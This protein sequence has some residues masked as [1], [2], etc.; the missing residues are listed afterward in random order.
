MPKELAVYDEDDIMME[1]MV[2]TMFMVMFIVVAIPIITNIATTA[3]AAQGVLAQGLNEPYSLTAKSAVQELTFTQAMQSVMIT[4][5]GN[6]TAY[7]KVNSL[8]NQPNEVRGGET[9]ELDYNTHVVERVFYYT[10]SGQTSLRVT[11]TG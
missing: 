1:T 6:T 9:L 3:I 4:N 11:G 7:I 2:T 8:N 10:L 5:D